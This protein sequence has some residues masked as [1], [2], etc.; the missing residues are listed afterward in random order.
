VV[1]PVSPASER[2]PRAPSQQ[3]FEEALPE[4]GRMTGSEI[5]ERFLDNRVR[6]SFQAFRL[7]SEDPGGSAQE[8]RFTIY[9]RDFRDANS[10][11]VNGILAK[12]LIEIT[13]PFDLRHTAYLLIAKDPGPN[14]QFVYR[15]ESRGVRR[16]D[17]RRS[18]LLGTDYSFDDLGF[19]H[20]DD[21]DYHRLPD[22]AVDGRAVYVVEAVIKTESQSDYGRTLSYIDQ[23]HYIPLR[24]RYWDRSG[25]ETKEMTAKADSIAQFGDVWVARES[26]M[27]NNLEQTLSTM[28]VE[29]LDPAPEFE[30]GLF[31]LRRLTR[32]H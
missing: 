20:L 25:V 13:H 3:E 6:A 9:L 23:E 28:Y 21:A 10:E 8:T 15:P 4:G 27:R 29:R 19:Q 5:F 1:P 2:Q 26:S 7:V 32:G 30:E 18:T 31:S 12:T 14:D 24:T 22:N 17:L 11:P 16:V